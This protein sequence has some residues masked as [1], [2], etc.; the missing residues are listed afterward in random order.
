MLTE[1]ALAEIGRTNGP[2][3][4]STPEGKAS[5]KDLLE[6]ES[7][8]IWRLKLKAVEIKYNQRDEVDIK[9]V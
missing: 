4:R 2:R 1:E 8:V 5:T 7:M 9:S 6:R 3:Q